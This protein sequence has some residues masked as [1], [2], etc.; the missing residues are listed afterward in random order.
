M[1]KGEL[2]KDNIKRQNA[3]QYIDYG[4][5]SLTKDSNKHL[6][7]SCIMTFMFSLPVVILGKW[8]A[9]I[10]FIITVQLVLL[11]IFNFWIKKDIDN[12]KIYYILYCGLTPV[13]ISGV[14]ML[15][16]WKL[17]ATV[18]GKMMFFSIILTLIYVVPIVLI[19]LDGF[20]RV[21]KGL[22]KKNSKY[23]GLGVGFF[24]GIGALGMTFG[25][26]VFKHVRQDTSMVIMAIVL[27]F[28]ATIIS[29]SSNLILKYY[30]CK[31]YSISSQEIKE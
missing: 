15:G 17:F 28:L 24:C 25:K 6:K 30:L 7:S 19:V 10:L 27:I 14:L 29:L 22:N 2:M 9:V 11:T 1:K 13:Y 26:V 3:I 23:V 18:Y 12:R 5:N 20:N 8:S 21:N 31:K 16:A 4:L